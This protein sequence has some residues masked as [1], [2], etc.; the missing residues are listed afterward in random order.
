MNMNFSDC[1]EVLT[2]GIKQDRNISATS[3]L[4]YAEIR[5]RAGLN[6]PV[7]I[8]NSILERVFNIYIRTVQRAIAELVANKYLKIEI[9]KRDTANRVITVLK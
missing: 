5:N 7:I 2:A 9:D 4:I 1:D 3:K 8:N 6:K